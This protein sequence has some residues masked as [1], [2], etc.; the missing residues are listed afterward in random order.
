MH[1]TQIMNQQARKV[2]EIA[3]WVGDNIVEKVRFYLGSYNRSRKSDKAT[4]IEAKK[5][6]IRW[7]DDMYGSQTCCTY[8]TT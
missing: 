4:N 6:M 1:P 3:L 7:N 5:H 2:F 8:A